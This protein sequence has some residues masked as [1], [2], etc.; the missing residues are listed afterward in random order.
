M[1]DSRLSSSSRRNIRASDEVRGETAV[2]ASKGRDRD[3]NR[4][5]RLKFRPNNIFCKIEGG[6]ASCYSLSIFG[7]KGVVF[8]FF[9]FFLIFAQFLHACDLH[10]TDY[11]VQRLDTFSQ[12]GFFRLWH[13]VIAKTSN[14]GNKT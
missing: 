7:G 11:I 12:I 2:W 14:I 13:L 9:F 6:I 8:F 10:C 1:H 3:L 4:L 5:E